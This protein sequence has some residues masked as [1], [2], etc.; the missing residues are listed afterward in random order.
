M[1]RPNPQEQEWLA[2]HSRRV[3]WRWFLVIICTLILVIGVS[4]SRRQHEPAAAARAAELASRSAMAKSAAPE[5][6]GRHPRLPR[7]AS[8]PA[9]TAEQV[10][11]GKLAQFGR[12]RRE[13]ARLLA[14]RHK[15]QI[16]A[17]VER[18]FQAVESGNWDAIK[19]AFDKIS[20]AEANASS[21]SKRSPEVNQLWPAI[22][23][24]YG[25]AEQVHL[26]PAQQLLDYG[27]SILDAL[28]PGM[29]YVGGTDH[30][31]WIPE[32]LNDTTDGE[33]HIVITQNG[34]AAGDYL[35][36]V[37]LQYDGRMATLSDEDSQQAFAQYVA[38]AQPRFEHD[39]QF[40]DEPKQVLPGEDL[41][42][43]D[44]KLQ[45]AG[46]TAVMAINQ[47]LLET[48]MGKNQG[49]SFGMEESFPLQG[50]YAQALPLGPLME[51]N[52]GSD[53]NTFTAEQA[54][55]SLDYWRE[56]AQQ[57]LSDADAAGST[58]TLKTYSHDAAAAANL[59]AAH[60]FPAQ[61]EEAYGLAA[62]F[63]PENPDT[64]LGLAGLLAADGRAND[65]RQLLDDF[66]R[67]YPDQRKYLD[68]SSAVVQGL[69]KPTPPQ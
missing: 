31:R 54:T 42:M 58:Y 18:F 65:A 52:A 41:T 55:Q 8:V 35:E 59:L 45:V 14:E 28:R 25:V 6:M 1:P 16:P 15:I 62:Q 68:Q 39:Q 49:L 44:G 5:R 32:L 36:Y 40:P 9:L 7:S 47:T 63:W 21:S 57:V 37:R 13:L 48:L 56:T 29:V 38:E 43:A 24:A 69:W 4:R 50:T 66:A 64:A 27:N 23:D 61:A 2:E 26:W 53:Q 60:N 22:I 67:Q 11:A 34:L 46:R 10:V 30:G 19:A 33:Q 12:S 17:D 3:R 20:G 51:L